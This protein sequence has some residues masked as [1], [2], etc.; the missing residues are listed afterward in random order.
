M[1]ALD[2]PEQLEVPLERDVRIVPALDQDLHATDRLHLV[3]LRP[4]LFV[5]ERPAFAVLWAAVEGAKAAVGDAD[6]GVVDVS[7]DDVRDH[8]L[9]MEAATHGVGSST[10]LKQRC[11][12]EVLEEIGFVRHRYDRKEGGGVRGEV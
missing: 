10:E 6:V 4:D 12:G 2:V 5:A 1:I 11:L 7:I 8:R 9:R 3:D